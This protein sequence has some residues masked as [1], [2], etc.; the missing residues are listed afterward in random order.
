MIKDDTIA[1]IATPAGGAGGIGIVRISGPRA[2]EMCCLFFQPASHI[3]FFK[4]RYLY[5]GTIVSQKTGMSIDEVLVVIMR[6]PHSFTGE[7]GLEIHCHG[8]T[9]ILQTILREL[10]EQGIRL[11]DPGEFTRRAFLNGRIDLSQAEAI[12][13]IVTAKTNKALEL[14]FAHLQGD[15]SHTIESYRAS[16]IEILALL[17][18]MIDFSEDDVCLPAESELAENLNTLIADLERTVKSYEEGKIYYD[19]F[20][21]EILGRPNVGKSSLLNSLLGSDRVLVTPLP[22]TTRDYIE[23]II[24]IRGIPIQFIDTAGLRDTDEIIEKTGIE[25]VWAKT[26]KADVIIFLLDG[27]HSLTS[28]DFDIFDRIRKKKVILA[29]NKMDLPSQISKEDLYKFI[30]ESEPVWL[31]AKFGEGISFLKENIYSMVVNGFEHS[32]SEIVIT[33]LRH[34]VAMENAALLLKQAKESFEKRV[35]PE[36]ISLDIHDS[37]NCLEEIVGRTTNEDV[38]DRI[39]SSFCIGK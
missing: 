27:S 38:L 22:G 5:H 11:A 35:S 4:N 1:A 26:A 21:A 39:F 20:S 23:E 9:T 33:N 36:F 19:G 15:V 13:D 12:Q 37:L 32:E 6:G 2:E 16:L 31:S 28:E 30:P 18:V 29:V 14:A 7:D 8:G 10:I 17:E 3:D 25:R 24:N 34:K